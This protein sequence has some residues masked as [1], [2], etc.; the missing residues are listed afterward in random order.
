MTKLTNQEQFILN[1]MQE[2]VQPDNTIELEPEF[3]TDNRIPTRGVDSAIQSLRRKSY[4]RKLAELTYILN[5]T[6]Y[7]AENES[8]AEL[9]WDEAEI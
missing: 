1:A 6:E 2:Y 3:R 9:I 8:E 7:P 4:L 5:P